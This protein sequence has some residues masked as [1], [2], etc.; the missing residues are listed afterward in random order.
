MPQR[1]DE[2]DAISRIEPLETRRVF[3]IGYAEPGALPIGN[4]NGTITRLTRYG[5]A[6]LDGD[7]DAA[8]FGTFARNF[9]RTPALWQHG[10]FNYDNVVNA[11]DFDKIAA[12]F[13]VYRSAAAAAPTAAD[14]SRLSDA[15][16]LR[17]TYNVA[18]DGTLTISG[19]PHIDHIAV[20][21]ALLATVGTQFP[22]APRVRRVVVDAGAG[23]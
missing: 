16:G 18:R 11:Y 12:N 21:A 2:R 7:V 10:D 1:P 6:D 4:F 15:V 19:T 3:G 5:D 23:D 9:G 13:G 20:D 17:P 22:G 8:D 14:W